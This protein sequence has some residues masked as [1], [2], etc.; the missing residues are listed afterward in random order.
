MRLG[1][2]HGRPFRRSR[3]ARSATASLCVVPLNDA[4]PTTETI[5]KGLRV[6]FGIGA[7]LDSALW[8]YESMRE[9]VEVARKPRGAVEVEVRE[10]EVRF[11]IGRAVW[12]DGLPFGQAVDRFRS[13][14]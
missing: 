1:R 4:V 11:R 3:P 7:R 13:R 6:V 14:D 8:D 12:E 10:G 5:R 9:A 2:H